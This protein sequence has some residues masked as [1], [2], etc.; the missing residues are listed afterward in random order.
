MEAMQHTPAQVF[1]KT[2]RFADLHSLNILDTPSDINFARFTR[3]AADVFK[4]PMAAVS[5]IDGGRRW[6]ESSVRIDPRQTPLEEYFGVQGLRQ[7]IVEVSDTLEDGFFCHHP[8][9]TGGPLIRF[10]MGAVLR[11]PNGEPLGTLS[12]MDTEPRYFTDA[13]RSW[14]VK[15]GHLVEDLINRNHAMTAARKQC[16]WEG[17]RNA[18]TGLPEET[19]FGDTL[20]HLLRLSEQKGHYLAVLHL[21]LNRIDEITRIHGR[22]NRDSILHCLAGR[23][24]APDI[25]VLAAGHLSEARFGA[26][27][28]LG[29]VRELFDVIAPIVDKLSSPI[30]LQSMTLRPD[31]DVGVSVSPLDG[32]TP[33]DLLQRAGAA[34]NGPSSREGVHVFSHKVEGDAL[35]QHMIEQRLEPALRENRLI[36][37]YQPMVTADGRRIVGFEALARWQDDRLGMVSPTEFLPVAEENARLS[38][39]LT[40]WSL[41]SVCERAPHW[42][43]QPGDGPL[44]IAIN[45]PAGQ[46][47]EPGFV[48]R[49]LRTLDEQELAPER[50]TLEL[51][52]ESLMVNV[53]KAVH[54]MRELRSHNIAMSLDDFGTG[55]SS[56][57]Y[58]KMLPIDNLKIDK[59][60]IDDLVDD[61]QAIDIVDG[62]VRI[63]HA[64][65]LEVVAEGVEHTTQHTLLNQAKCDVM[66]GYLFSR[67]L[68]ADD[69]LALF[70][71]WRLA[72][73]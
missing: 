46:F 54:T 57:S 69:A 25:K 45:I 40:D 28:A 33:E 42:P 41:R 68:V 10:Y 38:R 9:V 47:Y 4:V 32:A 2:E 72:H 59:S 8:I 15:L 14:L 65:D 13:Q 35:R 55:C 17:R 22:R 30:E 6:C 66:Q 18:R 7:E 58:L 62:I 71:N 70:K 20:Q 19:L 12:I 5:L 73:E 53:D 48:D 1:S 50:L 16:S 60:F 64:L 63:A 26:V 11:G 27:I 44:R 31:I 43:L 39:L 52:E 34:L 56:L 49:V 36:K 67:P 24:T 61:P 29:A 3:L 21:R 51:T 37:H 23:L